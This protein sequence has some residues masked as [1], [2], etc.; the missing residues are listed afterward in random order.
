MSHT[1]SSTTENNTKVSYRGDGK[2]TAHR[3]VSHRQGSTIEN[4]RKVSHRG[5]GKETAQG[6]VSQ[7]QG[8]STEKNRMVSDREDGEETAQGQVSDRQGSSTENNRMVSDREDGKEKGQRQLCQ[9]QG[10]T[11]E[12]NREIANREDGKETAQGRVSQGQG[13]STEK[14]RMVSDREDGEETP[15]GQVSHSQGSRSEDNTEIANRDDEKE[16]AQGRVSH[17]EGSTTEENR[18]EEGL[19][20]NRGISVKEDKQLIPNRNKDEDRFNN[21]TTVAEDF[22]SSDTKEVRTTNPGAINYQSTSQSTAQMNP[23]G[24]NHTAY[25]FPPTNMHTSTPVNEASFPFMDSM[26]DNLYSENV[27]RNFSVQPAPSG[28]PTSSIFGNANSILYGIDNYVNDVPQQSFHSTE[29]CNI[30]NNIKIRISIDSKIPVEISQEQE[31]HGHMPSNSF[32][33]PWQNDSTITN[34]LHHGKDPSTDDKGIRGTSEI[35][36]NCKPYKVNMN[37]HGKY[38]FTKTGDDKL[39]EVE[40]PK[41]RRDSLDSCCQTPID[42][43]KQTTY[44]I[45]NLL[46]DTSTEKS[47]KNSR[48]KNS[49]SLHLIEE[50]RPIEEHIQQTKWKQVSTEE[51]KENQQETQSIKWKKATNESIKGKEVIC[52]SSER[53]PSLELKK[54]TFRRSGETESSRNRNDTLDKAKNEI[55]WNDRKNE[56]ATIKG[57]SKRRDRRTRIIRNKDNNV[58]IDSTDDNDADDEEDES[59]NLQTNEETEQPSDEEEINEFT[60]SEKQFQETNNTDESNDESDAGSEEG[61]SV[62]NEDRG[63]RQVGVKG[64]DEAAEEERDDQDEEEEEDDDGEDTQSVKTYV[65]STIRFDDDDERSPHGTSS[66]KG[67]ITIMLQIIQSYCCT[68]LYYV[69]KHQI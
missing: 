66:P 37:R 67:N 10:T 25:W 50:S 59:A 36:I 40:T 29:E 1:Q 12:H 30:G 52:K 4:K 43:K 22:R 61:G 2:E 21:N 11:R 41:K 51:I 28:N 19:K 8:F 27:M 49:T 26:M 60:S 15:Q 39:P 18:E 33:K 58:T 35:G 68:I 13:F 57:A 32:C 46:Q 55:S 69:P 56:V 6:R 9:G 16:A 17:R 14:N 45:N 62:R 7:G 23:Y 31:Q 42:W 48:K 3:Q 47:T 53:K 5:D 63:D 65:K 38:S 54:K 24:N 34:S 44:D 20:E 64:I